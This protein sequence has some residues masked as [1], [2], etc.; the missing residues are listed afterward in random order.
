MTTEVTFTTFTFSVAMDRHEPVARRTEYGAGEWFDRGYADGTKA[1]RLSG[2]NAEIFPGSPD[3]YFFLVDTGDRV[4]PYYVATYTVRQAV[5][6]H[7]FPTTS[8]TPTRNDDGR[9]IIWS[10]WVMGPHKAYHLVVNG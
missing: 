6:L 4:T 9:G 5:I 2:A 10:N 1:I 3:A 8:N 7:P